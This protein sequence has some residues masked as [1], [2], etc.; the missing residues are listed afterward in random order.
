KVL[1]DAKAS[2][3]LRR[4]ALRT[5]VAARDKQLPP[6][7]QGLVRDSVLGGDA[8]RG[9]ASFDDAKTPKILLDAYDKLDSASRRDAVA[10]LA[11]RVSYGRALL[12]AVAAKKMPA[13]H[14]SAEVIRQLGNLKDK[15]ID[16]RIG[17]VW[18]TVRSTPKERA[19]LIAAWK[20][21]LGKKPK[22]GPD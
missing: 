10:T 15:Q 8:I 16:K 1:T 18:G 22:V 11:S 9:L 17:E 5:L 14:L 21:R 12:E 7:L 13:N 4:E 20:K 6:V 3:N 19:A 2:A